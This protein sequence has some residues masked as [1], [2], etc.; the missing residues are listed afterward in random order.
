V[1]R[2]RDRQH[3]SLASHPWE[4]LDESARVIRVV[5]EG[6]KGGSGNLSAAAFAL[7][8]FATQSSYSNKL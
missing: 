1:A 2:H 5:G 3:L 7:Y 6:C 8:D 4:D